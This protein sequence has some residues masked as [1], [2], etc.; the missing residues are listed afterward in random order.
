M[1]PAAPLGDGQT[2]LVV[3]DNE[4][5]RHLAIRRLE[6]ACYRVLATA[7]AAAAMAIIDSEATIDLL[8]TDI[9]MEGGVNGHDLARL[10]TTRRPTLP[11]LLTSGFADLH[12]EGEAVTRSS[13]RL[14][15]KPY[16]SEELLRAIREALD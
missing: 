9:V 13:H 15:H 7:D 12:A 4:R 6:A 3:E 11:V 5:L 10:A 1:S 16:R 8:F 2:I 14:L